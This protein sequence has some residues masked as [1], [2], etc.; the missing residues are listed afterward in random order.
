MRTEEP[1]ED[2]SRLHKILETLFHGRQKDVLQFLDRIRKY[3]KNS[4]P[5]ALYNYIADC[6]KT[7]RELFGNYYLEMHDPVSLSEIS[8]EEQVEDTTTMFSEVLKSLRKVDSPRDKR[9]DVNNVD[10][11]E[12]YEDVLEK[13]YQEFL[14]DIN[15]RISSVQ[16]KNTGSQ[17][18]V[19]HHQDVYGG[20]AVSSSLKELIREENLEAASLNDPEEDDDELQVQEEFQ[21]KL[22]EQNQKYLEELE[23]IR[24]RRRQQQ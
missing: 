11:P 2:S 4:F 21:R 17:D 10:P 13:Q 23:K 14:K 15:M 16:P 20:E 5:M 8:H 9:M 24:Q 3:I 12:S 19:F 7:C 1:S 22:A 6:Y 18:P